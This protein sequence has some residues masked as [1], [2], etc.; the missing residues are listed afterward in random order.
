MR[1][2]SEIHRGIFKVEIF[3]MIAT[4]KVFFCRIAIGTFYTA[5]FFRKM[6]KFSTFSTSSKIRKTYL[7]RPTTRQSFS[8]IRDAVRDAVRDTVRD[9]VRDTVRDALKC[10]TTRCARGCAG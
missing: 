9:A 1:S 5:N 8:K 7:F 3:L 6:G 2:F 10:A 4:S